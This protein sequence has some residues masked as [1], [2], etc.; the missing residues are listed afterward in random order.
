MATATTRDESRA[1][2]GEERAPSHLRAGIPHP[3]L[4]AR[5]DSSVERSATRIA[6]IYLAAALAWIVC[7]RAF[8]ANSSPWW[9]RTSGVMNG[10]HTGP[11]FS[12]AV[13]TSRKLSGSLSKPAT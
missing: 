1:V 3:S 11:I 13:A 12:R 10:V 6:L 5:L 9:R 4:G 8:N 7:L 2:P